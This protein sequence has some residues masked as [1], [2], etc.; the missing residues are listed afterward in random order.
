[1]KFP[2][3]L[4]A[5]TSALAGNLLFV[6][7]FAFEAIRR[8]S[9]LPA[10]TAAAAAF[11]SWLIVLGIEDYCHQASFSPRTYFDVNRKIDD[12]FTQSG[13]EAGDSLHD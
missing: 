4:L 11:S 6:G 13:S 10:L 1:M 9:I 8:R 3:A 2:K 7:I 5:M 12:F